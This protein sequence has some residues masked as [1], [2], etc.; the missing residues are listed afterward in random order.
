MKTKMPEPEIITRKGK[1]VSVIL[2]IDQ[3]QEML[4]RLEDADDIAWLKDTRK[5]PQSFRKLEDVLAD[6]GI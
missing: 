3:Y 4:E 5:K 2:P 6:L 1:A